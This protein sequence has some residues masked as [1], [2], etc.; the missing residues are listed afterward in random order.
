MEVGA[1]R[2]SS[3]RHIMTST[4]QDRKRAYSFS[5][6]Q[7]YTPKAISVVQTA[8]NIANNYILSIK[9]NIS[10]DNTFIQPRNGYLAFQI[11][12]DIKES[13]ELYCVPANRK[14][15]VIRAD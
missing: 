15:I 10:L 1:T 12:V 11:S 3:H 6:L 5:Q 9:A 14:D 8:Y 13:A 4:W 2:V 7:E